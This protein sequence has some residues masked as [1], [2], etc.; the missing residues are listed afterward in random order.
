MES[1]EVK[2]ENIAFFSLHPHLKRAIFLCLSEEILS[3]L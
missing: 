2:R 3:C 1:F